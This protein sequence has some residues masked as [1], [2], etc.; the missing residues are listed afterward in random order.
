MILILYS[1]LPICS[2]FISFT[3][4][5]STVNSRS[6]AASF[7][8]KLII[9]HLHQ[10]NKKNLIKLTSNTNDLVLFFAL[11]IQFFPGAFFAIGCRV[12]FVFI[13]SNHLISFKYLSFTIEDPCRN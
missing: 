6:I 4:I 7:I 5:T 2:R 13:I 8:T 12:I 9:F 11:G 10:G 3:D 1:K